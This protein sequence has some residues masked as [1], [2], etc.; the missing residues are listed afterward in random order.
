M[1]MHAQSLSATFDN[2][3]CSPNDGEDND[4][5]NQEE[6]G[7]EWLEEEVAKLE[8]DKADVQ[9]AKEL[10]K[11]LPS[12]ILTDEKNSYLN[13]LKERKYGNYLK[14]PDVQEGL[15]SLADTIDNLLEEAKDD[16][17]LAKE[18]LDAEKMSITSDNDNKKE[19]LEPAKY[20]EASESPGLMGPPPKPSKPLSTPTEYIN[21]Q[22]MCEM[23]PN[24]EPD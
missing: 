16:L 5:D 12:N 14:G 2:T 23:P 6:G 15:D 21:E 20:S 24:D 7:L 11:R 18:E 10:D 19:D 8:K 4:S 22:A 1:Y 3:N 13:A 9:K 17:N